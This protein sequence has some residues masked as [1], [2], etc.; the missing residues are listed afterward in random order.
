MQ[1]NNYTTFS[2]QFKGLEA[3]K[4]YFLDKNTVII[5]YDRIDKR[6]ICCGNIPH[7][8]DYRT[9][10]IKHNPYMGYIVRLK[11]KK[12]RYK[13]LICK[14]I[15]TSNLDMIKPK[16]RIA[17]TVFKEFEIQIKNIRSIKDISTSLGISFSRG[18]IHFDTMVVKKHSKELITTIYMDEFKGNSNNEKYQLAIYNQNKE[19]IDIL[20]NRKSPKLKEWFKDNEIKPNIFVTDMFM[21]FRNVITSTFD[22]PIIVADKYHVLR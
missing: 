22:N 19:L 2:I 12:Q 5:E 11:V 8:H 6:D 18:Y 16:C 7:I 1:Q 9:V 15:K 4:S 10:T 3:K 13:C 20:E 17:D 14:K 21:Q